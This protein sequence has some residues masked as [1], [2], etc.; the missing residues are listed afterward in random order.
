MQKLHRIFLLLF[1][2][3]V[4]MGFLEGIVVV[5]VRQLY[6]PSGFDFPLTLLSPEMLKIEWLREITTLVMLGSIAWIAGRN[7]IQRLSFFLFTF[8]IWDIFYY[9][10]LKWI[11]DWPSSLLTWDVLFLIPVPWLGPL[12]A[13]V[14][15]SLVMI[16]MAF[17]Y[18]YLAEAGK[19]LKI[20]VSDWLLLL[21]GSAVI[22]FTFIRDYLKLI[23]NSN[24]LTNGNN[25][26]VKE[27]FWRAITSF[28][29]GHYSWGLFIT[30]L[31]L[32]LIS[33]FMVVR[34]AIFHNSLHRQL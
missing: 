29:P 11:L 2:F 30:G 14:I 1:I 21:G 17:L 9:V 34:R 5:Y 13:P 12:L 25:S 31:L 19:P 24:I 16:L 18:T 23:S 4:A 7:F 28:I 20:K 33:I 22:F 32:I 26:A 10:L 8:G 6:Y 27:E 15:C 3:A